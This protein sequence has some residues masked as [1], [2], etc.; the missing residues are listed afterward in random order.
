MQGPELFLKAQAIDVRDALDPRKPALLDSTRR[1][2]IG[3]DLFYFADAASRARFERDPLR[4]SR[5]LTD[6][7]TLARF[8]PSARSRKATHHGRRYWFANDST[9]M[10]V[11]ATPDSFAVRKGM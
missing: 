6:P 10:A 9:W 2:F 11:R 3:H 8:A 4:W 1:A 5:R 7:V